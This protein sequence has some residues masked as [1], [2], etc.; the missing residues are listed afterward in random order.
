MKRLRVLHIIPTMNSG[1][2]AEAVLERLIG[3][4]RANVH[5]VVTLLETGPLGERLVADG[6]SVETLGLRGPADLP[7]AL[8]R[9]RTLLRAARPDVVQTWMYHADLLG[10]VLARLCGIRCV[11][12]G[13]H[14]TTFERGGSSRSSRLGAR[15]C[16]LLS[17]QVPRRVVSCSEAG[18]APHVALGYRADRLVV[19]HN[20]YDDRVFSPALPGVNRMREERGIAAEVRL[21]GMAARWDPQKDH[22]TLLRAL[23]ELARRACSNGTTAHDWH[24]LLF[25][26]RIDADNAALCALIESC[27][28]SDR[29]TLLG[30]RRDVVDVMRSLD[31]AVLSSR[32]GEAFPN[33][34]NESM[35]VGVPC[36]TTAVGDAAMIVGDTGW[37]VPPADPVALAAALAQALDALQVPAD[38]QRRQHACR[39]R[40]ATHFSVSRMRDGYDAVWREALG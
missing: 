7:R 28:L 4:N 5:A 35:L 23:R 3:A 2:G 38:W 11:V 31:V 6:T 30:S 25:G 13:L 40:I 22:G 26:T 33:V 9:L 18:I 14:H 32:F 29:V 12:W 10:G 20:G 16:A 8:W 1:G 34:L 24:C 17:G 27:G 39:E 37:V 19:V 15:L 21:I 36:V